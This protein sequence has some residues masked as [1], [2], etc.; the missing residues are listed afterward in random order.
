MNNQN[1]GFAKESKAEFISELR[2]KVKLYFEREHISKYANP[3]MILKTIFMLLLYFIPYGLMISGAI[4]NNWLVLLLWA[5]MGL[6]MS[7]IGLSIMHDAN[8]GSYSKNQQ[9]NKLL[10]YFMNIIGGNATNWKLQ[11]NVLHHAYTNIDGLDEDIDPGSF[12]RF[13]PHSKRYK[14]HRLQHIY[15]WFL[16]SLMSISWVLARDYGQLIRYKKMG[17]MQKQNRTFGFR[18]TELV[19]SKIF[20]L[21]YIV[22]LPLIFSGATWWIILIGFLIMHMVTGFLLTIIF[23]PAHVMPTSEFPLPDEK[24][25]LENNWAV[26]Q[27]HTTCDFA[28]HSRL[29]SWYVGGLNYQIEHHLFPNICHV[30]Y[31]KISEIVRTTAQKYSLPYNV[32]PTFMQALIQHG[33]MLRMLGRAD[34]V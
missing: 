12:L 2:A 33:R 31:R 7:G 8:H 14:I 28:P 9:I 1:I 18:F 30:H 11:H 13:S 5:I 26:H 15:A 32:Q 20:Y 21:A 10:G 3:G 34:A 29:F 6:G 16:Y 25:T 23:Q 22:V 4:V 19:V 17:L 24:G 27:L